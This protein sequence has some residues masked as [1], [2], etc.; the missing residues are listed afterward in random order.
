MLTTSIAP[1]MPHMAEDAW[2]NLP[3]K[4]EHKSVFEYGLQKLEY[5]PHMS[6]HW[7]TVR[8]IKDDVNFA[9]EAARRGGVIGANNECEVVIHAPDAD[10][11]ALIMGIVGDKSILEH[12]SP[13]SIADDLRFILIASSVKIVSTPAEVTSACGAEYTL[14]LVADQSESGIVVGVRKAPG[15]K[16]ERCWFYSEDVGTH[17]GQDGVCPRCGFAASQHAH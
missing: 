9:M 7:A 10:L 8:R 5:P 2:L 14:G 12:P 6:D 11:E 13:V 15:S 4:A 16:C 3:W 17:H 1:L